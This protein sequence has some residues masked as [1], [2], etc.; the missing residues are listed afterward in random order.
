MAI[1][2]ALETGRDIFGQVSFG[3]RVILMIACDYNLGTKIPEDMYTID[4]IP[5]PQQTC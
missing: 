1:P 3:R 5:T 4:N 2:N